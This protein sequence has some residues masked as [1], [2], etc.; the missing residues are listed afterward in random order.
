MLSIEEAVAKYDGKT[1]NTSVNTMI[2]DLGEHYTAHLTA[3]RDGRII[4]V[5]AIITD[6]VADQFRQLW[7]E[8]EGDEYDV[9][10]I[11]KYAPTE[12][13]R[14][15]LQRYGWTD[16]DDDDGHFG[17][18]H[19]T[20]PGMAREFEFAMTNVLLMPEFLVSYT[21]EVKE[22]MEAFYTK[23]GIDIPWKKSA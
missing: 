23:K 1:I 10:Y 3:V 14:R 4:N 18:G 20:E 5:N 7:I 19:T 11:D 22:S 6:S 2:E 9:T 17:C 15:N 21:K 8:S 13:I 16:V 12:Y